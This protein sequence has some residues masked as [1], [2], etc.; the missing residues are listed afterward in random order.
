M[1]GLILAAA[2]AAP[3]AAADAPAAA[4]TGTWTAVEAQR[5]GTAA[6]DLVGHR[7]VFEGQGFSIVAPDG[8]PLYAGRYTA[9]AAAQP[10][11]ID[12]VQE[13]GE[14]KGQTW[15]GIWRLDGER[16]LTIIDDAPNPAKGRPVDFTAAKGSGHV[17][18]VFRR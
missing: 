5:D 11:R 15:E 2:L 1:R 8:E 16:R 10:F 17:M 4:L 18:V 13:A 9:D 6:P 14:A 12:F 3:A 7:L